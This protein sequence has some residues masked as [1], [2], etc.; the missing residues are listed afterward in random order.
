MASQE[1]GGPAHADDHMSQLEAVMWILDGDPRLASGFANLTIFDRVPDRAVLRERMLAATE[2]VPRL[3]QRVVG[4]GHLSTPV[5]RDDPDFDLDHHIRWIDLGDDDLDAL[6]A[7]LSGHPF[8]RERPLWEFV[9]VEGLPGGAG[10]M[11]Q[12]FDHTLTDGEGGIRLS[13][14]FLDLE[15]QPDRPHRSERPRRSRSD[16]APSAPVEAPVVAADGA[17]TTIEE[18]A[19]GLWGQALR[20]LRAAGS[21]PA[22]VARGAAQVPSRTGGFLDLAVDSVQQLAVDGRRSPLWTERSTERWFGRSALNLDD[23]KAAGRALGGSVNDVFVTGALTAAAEVH[24]A[25]GLPVDE[26]RVAIPVSNRQSGSSDGN[27]FT[28]VH[29]L[30]PTGDMPVEE[31]FRLVHERLDHVKRDQ[32]GIP[33]DA[34][35]AAARLLPNAALLGIAGRTAGAIDFVCSNVRAAPFDLYMAGAH[36]EGNYPL[37]P[38][39]NTSFNLTTMSYRGWLFL[40]LLADRVAVPDPD[41]LLAALERAYA[42]VL[43]AGGIATRRTPDV[44][45]TA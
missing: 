22:A 5:W 23:V 7:E 34:P 33:L 16:A 36:L 45:V 14:Q 31:R 25:A 27:A 9:V 10:A 6:A 1:P 32:A 18:P 40:G 8:D 3:R 28:P 26:L 12:R 11:V 44:P 19:P 4:G 38:L 15:R 29:A 30:L 37:G 24:A 21:V 41:G 42:E 13:A 35:A 43:A 20:G 39:L 2:V 17:A